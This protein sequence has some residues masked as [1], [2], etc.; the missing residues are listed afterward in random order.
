MTKRR[1]LDLTTLVLK[2]GAHDSPDAGMCVMEAAAYVAGRPHSDSPPC[3]S[4]VIAT[5]CRSWNDAM[6]DEDRQQ[7]K[8]YIA[9]ILDTATGAADEETRSWMALDWLCR[10]HTPAWLRLAGLTKEAEAIEST[11]RICD[12]VTARAAQP[13]L[14]DGRKRAAAAW[15]AARDAARAAAWAAARDAA[16]AA[17]WDAAWAAA[18]AA[19]RDAARDAARAAAWAAAGDAARAAAGDAVWDAARDAAWAAARDAA[20]AA[21]WAAAWDRLRPTVVT[22]QQSALGLLDEMCG[23]GRVEVAA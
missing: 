17:A 15:A 20:W 12:A 2:R 9:R 5:F 4:P 10:V 7:L 11:A 18:W 19:A 6:S 16:W 14:D 8:P 21:A 23:V 22:L 13:A 1:E 3:V